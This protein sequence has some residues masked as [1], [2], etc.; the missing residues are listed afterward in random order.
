MCRIISR[1]TDET[2]ALF[3]T[4]GS[5]GAMSEWYSDDKKTDAEKGNKKRRKGNADW[6]SAEYEEATPR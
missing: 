4:D 6:Q 1:E 2:G 3:F 5:G